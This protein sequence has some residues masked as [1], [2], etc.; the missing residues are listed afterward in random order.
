MGACYSVFVTVSLKDENGAINALNQHIRT[1]TRTSYN[2]ERYANIGATPD[3]FDGLMKILL[4]E[5]QQKVHIERCN[6]WLSYKN[7]F[8]AS[9]GWEDVM[10]DWFRILAPYLKDGSKMLIYPDEDYDELVVVNGTSVQL[11]YV[12]DDG[13]IRHKRLNMLT[14]GFISKARNPHWGEP[15]HG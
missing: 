5:I 10:M 7:D 14:D 13:Q 11:H 2:L 3:S 12:G 9:Y 15:T 8:T 6:D 1:D 4:A